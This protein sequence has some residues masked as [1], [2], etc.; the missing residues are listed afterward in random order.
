MIFPRFGAGDETT[1]TQT[2][3]SPGDVHQTSDDA[4]LSLIGKRQ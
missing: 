4:N 1:V 3:R 2:G